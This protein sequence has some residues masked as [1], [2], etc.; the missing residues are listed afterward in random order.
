MVLLQDT[1]SITCV[2][3]SSSLLQTSIHQEFRPQ[4]TLNFHHPIPLEIAAASRTTKVAAYDRLHTGLS[5]G[6][7]KVSVTLSPLNGSEGPRRLSFLLER[8]IKMFVLEL[9][10]MA[11]SSIS[12]EVEWN[13]LSEYLYKPSSH[14]VVDVTFWWKAP[15]ER[16]EERV[17]RLITFGVYS[18]FSG[19]Q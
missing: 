9:S 8:S 12:L 1:N 17:L 2:A 19:P 15:S 16:R 18:S 4:T 6:R 10:T 3:S 11:K 14:N 5:I 13:S 7:I